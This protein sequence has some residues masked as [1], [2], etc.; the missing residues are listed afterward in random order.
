M[1][2]LALIGVAA[3]VGVSTVACTE[4]SYY[5][6]R[7]QYVTSPAPYYGSSYY[8]APAPTYYTAPA[9]TTYYS[10]APYSTAPT[11][12]SGS[13]YSPQA[14]RDRDGVP[15]WRDTRPSNPYRY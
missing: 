6:S 14:D 2:A 9:T 8:A 4:D 15:N 10:T 12:Y 11:Y 3:L 7:P 1:R 5:N 13:S